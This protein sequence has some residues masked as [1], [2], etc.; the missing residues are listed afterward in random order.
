MAVPR[1]VAD[2]KSIPPFVESCA[3]EWNRAARELP[4]GVR[5]GDATGFSPERARALISGTD[6][7]TRSEAATLDNALGTDA[8]RFLPATKSATMA[9]PVSSKSA[10]TSRGA[11]AR[12][13]RYAVNAKQRERAEAWQERYER[14]GLS[15]R[16]IATATGLEYRKV[17]DFLRTG[18]EPKPEERRMLERILGEP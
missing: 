4:P 9:Q 12:A 13:P 7:A 17:F 18:H 2:T 6:A 16:E 8:A 5:I 1:I 3:A 11:R 10:T 14:S 15:L